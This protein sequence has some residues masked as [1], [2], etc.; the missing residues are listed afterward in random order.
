MARK[1]KSTAQNSNF[2]WFKKNAVKWSVAGIVVMGIAYTYESGRF[3]AKMP[4]NLATTLSTKVSQYAAPI[5]ANTACL[6]Q[7]YQ[8]VPPVLMKSSLN[9]NSYPLC[10]NGF[11][12]MYSGTSKTP[13]WSAEELTPQR[14]STN[15]KRQNNFHEETAVSNSAHRAT[16]KDYQGSGYDRGHM[17]PNGDM[18]DVQSQFDSFSLA[19]MV[20]QAP[21]NN[22][23]IWRELEEATRAVVK[24]Q[25][26]DVYVITGPLFEGSK[27]KTIG[28]GVLVPTTVFKAVYF[29][30]TGAI[31]AYYAP[32]NNSLQVN[33]VS[34]C[35]LEERLGISLFPQ[36]SEEQKRQIY[37]LPLNAG[38]VKAQQP[39]RLLREDMESQCAQDP[40]TEE[41]EATQKRFTSQKQP[42][43]NENNSQIP[44]QESQSHTSSSSHNRASESNTQSLIR[45]I[46]SA[47]I[48]EIR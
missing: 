11:S 24:K 30:K 37:N 15:I 43:L 29:P 26:Q 9:N 5:T 6:K 31:G 42:T 34:I 23:Q 3:S 18:P 35:Y 36:L 16:L 22:Q 38:M 41:I 8:G 7:F 2:N 20:P 39:I 46:I 12:V 13:L 14:L 40:S 1:R 4:E 19:N 44:T 21:K 45:Q 47:F 10:F 17:S 48:K 32:N 27:I 25:K 33:V 28:Q